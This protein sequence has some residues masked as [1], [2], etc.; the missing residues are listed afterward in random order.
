VIQ[1]MDTT[2]WI[3]NPRTAKMREIVSDKDAFGDVRVVRSWNCFFVA[4]VRW[5]L[6]MPNVYRHYGNK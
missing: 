2:M 6:E 3:H 1:F 5:N 4:K